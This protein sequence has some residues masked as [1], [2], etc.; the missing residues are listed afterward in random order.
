QAIPGPD[1]PTL[2]RAVTVAKNLASRRFPPEAVHRQ[3]IALVSLS[4]VL[5]TYALAGGTILSEV[6]VNNLPIKF[7]RPA[8]L[9]VMAWVIWAYFLYRYFLVTDAPWKA[10]GEEVRLRALGDR[11]VQEIC[12][13]A[14]PRFEV[15]A[16]VRAEIHRQLTDGWTLS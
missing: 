7:N 13:P 4:L 11:H 1:P 6:T 14:L 2:Q 5:L 16:P 3:R 8:V 12:L 15:A 9:L 10:F